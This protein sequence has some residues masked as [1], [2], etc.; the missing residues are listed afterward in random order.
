[1]GTHEPPEEEPVAEAGITGS[2]VTLTIDGE[3]IK[4]EAVPVGGDD[5]D[6]TAPL[7]LAEALERVRKIGETAKHGFLKPAYRLGRGYL[8]GAQKATES[9]FDGVVN[10]KNGEK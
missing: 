7:N 4:V 9:F 8:R 2:D 1:M 3:P 10:E 6:D 5:T